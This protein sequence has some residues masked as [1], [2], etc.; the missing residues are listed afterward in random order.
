MTSDMKNT[1]TK[2]ATTKEAPRG[3]LRVGVHSINLASISHVTFSGEVT[4]HF[5][6]GSF[7]CFPHRVDGLSELLEIFGLPALG[8]LKEAPKHPFNTDAEA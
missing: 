5:N 6:S 2:A 8:G 3:L 4:V 1:T 7:I